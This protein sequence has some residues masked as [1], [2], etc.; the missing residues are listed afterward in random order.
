MTSSRNGTDD[1]PRFSSMTLLAV[2]LPSFSY[3]VG[4]NRVHSDSVA[5]RTSSLPRASVNESKQDLMLFLSGE[6]V[7]MTVA[8]TSR[9]VTV[10]H[11]YIMIVSDL[12]SGRIDR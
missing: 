3:H 5:C 7:R 9:P 10:G 1:L 6:Y 2:L 4:Y 11:E 8:S 12:S